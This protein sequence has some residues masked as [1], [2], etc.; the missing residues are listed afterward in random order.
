MVLTL[1]YPYDTFTFVIADLVIHAL[2]ETI[3]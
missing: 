2:T 1:L 3:D